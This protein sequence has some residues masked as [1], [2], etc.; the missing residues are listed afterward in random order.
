M[1]FNVFFLKL[2]SWLNFGFLELWVLVKSFGI[3]GFCPVFCQYVVDKVNFNQKRKIYIGDIATIENLKTRTIYGKKPKRLTNKPKHYTSDIA[4]RYIIQ[5]K[6]Y[7]ITKSIYFVKDVPYQPSHTQRYLVYYSC[8]PNNKKNH[9]TILHIIQTFQ[10]DGFPS[11]SETPSG[12][13]QEVGFQ[14]NCRPESIT[15]S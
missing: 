2:W 7:C 1:T 11:K 8:K 13:N 10:E 15:P 12:Q 5:L 6:L 14:V 3:M 9:M 4:T